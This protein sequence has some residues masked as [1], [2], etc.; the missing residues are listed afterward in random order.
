MSHPHMHA[1]HSKKRIFHIIFTSSMHSRVSCFLHFASFP[2]LMAFFSCIFLP[3][4]DSFFFSP[5]LLS[6]CSDQKLFLTVIDRILW[7]TRR[8]RKKKCCTIWNWVLNLGFAVAMQKVK[9]PT[10]CAF[11]FCMEKIYNVNAISLSKYNEILGI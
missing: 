6:L 1:T 5:F 10:T 4:S 2:Y 8:S 11:F 3:S 7:F 9:L